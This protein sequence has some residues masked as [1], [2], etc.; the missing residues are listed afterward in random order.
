MTT[1]GVNYTVG[2]KRRFFPGFK[3]YQVIY[4]A[5]EHA[6]G[7]LELHLVDGSSLNVPGLLRRPWRVYPNYRSAQE[8]INR[9]R[10]SV[11]KEQAPPNHVLDLA[12]E[13]AFGEIL[14]AQAAGRSS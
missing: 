7:Q 1:V 6:T 14:A 2:V 12:A 8:K 11:R 10:E 4:H 13:D 5:Y 3:T 9:L